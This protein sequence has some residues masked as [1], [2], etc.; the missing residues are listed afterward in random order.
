MFTIFSRK[1]K[2]VS[3]HISDWDDVDTTSEVVFSRKVGNEF[4]PFYIN[5]MSDVAV[6]TYGKG[7]SMGA[8]KKVNLLPGWNEYLLTEIIL[9][10]GS[11]IQWGE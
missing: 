11:L 10:A 5:N 1:G 2:K 9:P 3:F 4:K 7:E 6:P 8:R